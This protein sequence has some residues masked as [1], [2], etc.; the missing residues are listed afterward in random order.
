MVTGSSRFSAI[1]TD[2]SLKLGQYTLSTPQINALQIK[3]S[4]HSKFDPDEIIF[5]HRLDGQAIK[6]GLFVVA[7]PLI[8]DELTYVA[9]CVA[10][11]VGEELQI[12]DLKNG[13]QIFCKMCSNTHFVNILESGELAILCISEL[14]PDNK[15]SHTIT[16]NLKT[17]H[18]RF[19][20]LHHSI[21]IKKADKIVTSNSIELEIHEDDLLAFDS[22]PGRLK[23]KFGRRK[24]I[25]VQNTGRILESKISTRAKYRLY[26]PDEN[27]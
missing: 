3:K 2:Q 17:E 16:F 20:K 18:S 7:E 8:G 25:T 12:F 27:Y 22:S 1:S 15:Y 23:K 26:E 24:R 5:T 10:K 11:E 9:V 19:S 21:G 13:E 4:G 6:A 14:G